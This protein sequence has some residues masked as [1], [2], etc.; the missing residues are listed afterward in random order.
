MP[1]NALTAALLWPRDRRIRPRTR[2]QDSAAASATVGVVAEVGANGWQPLVAFVHIPRTGGGSVTTAISKTYAEAKSVGNLQRG[3]AKTH[4]C[5]A[6]IRDRIENWSGRFLADHV[7]YG[8]YRQYLP[9]DTR[10]I[11]FLRD[12]V[13]R[14]L[15]HYHFHARQGDQKLQSIWSRFPQ[16]AGIERDHHARSPRDPSNGV[17]GNADYSLEVGL[18][19]GIPIYSNMATRF[20]WDGDWLVDE[21]PS[22]ALGQA[23][24][25]IANFAF[26]GITERLDESVVL[27]GEAF[28]VGLMPYWLRH[29]NATRPADD[30]TPAELRA[31]I[32]EHNALD[33]EL[34]RFALQR[35][36]EAA[37][38][39]G[40]L[41]PAV[42]QLRR[43][44]A[45]VTEAAEAARPAKKAAR[46]ERRVQKAEVKLAKTAASDEANGPVGADLPRADARILRRAAKRARQAGTSANGDL[47]SEARQAG[48]SADL[49]SELEALERRL[50]ALEAA[51]SDL[52][53]TPAPQP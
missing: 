16:A 22:D 52:K 33:L 7:P 36:D 39:A 18:A 10:Y 23:K 29:V 43:R 24:Q 25:N 30:E 53:A 12:P 17:D 20:L 51:V 35:F 37:A 34:Y 44:S 8:V 11:T 40:D 50:T 42:E 2:D 21:L 45:E 41:T 1:Q 3:P 13:G 4:R 14:V 15:S 5:L 9:D 26:V 48:T 31:L 47:R 49:R 28:G 6:G 19:R 38:A 46:F 27:L 32:E